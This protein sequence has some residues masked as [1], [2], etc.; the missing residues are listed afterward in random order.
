MKI[1]RALLANRK[2][3]FWRSL[4]LL[5][6]IV[7]AVSVVFWAA[8]KVVAVSA[9]T[10]L[11]QT[12]ES[13]ANS[14]WAFPAVA[15][16]FT[17][18]SFAGAPQFLLIALAVAAFGPVEGFIYSYLGTLISASVN[19]FVAWRL[20]AG[21]FASSRGATL[22]SLSEFVGRNGFFS[23]MIVRIVPSAPFVVVNMGMGVAG[24]PYWSFLAGT[25]VGIIPKTAM[26]A[27]FGKMIERARAGDADA[28]LYLV[29]LVLAW[30][31]IALI[32]RWFLNRR[33]RPA[34]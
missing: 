14:H 19:F 22:A 10:A 32:A 6:L 1:I 9:A 28:I 29:T 15:A 11:G 17:A 5:V 20:G 34:P 16:V 7:A 25:A 3:G 8:G 26:I 13:V 33:A 4:V 18:A 30:L 21:W 12:F 27:L 2:A 23:A 24:V 31:G